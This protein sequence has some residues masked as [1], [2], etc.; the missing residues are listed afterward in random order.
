LA[1]EQALKRHKA[2]YHSEGV[3][4]FPSSRTA[5]VTDGKAAVLFKL[6]NANDLSALEQHLDGGCCSVTNREGDTLLHV[7]ARLRNP[8]LALTVLR[9]A[10]GACPSS[11]ARD[12]RTRTLVNVQ[13]QRG[14][15]ALARTLRDRHYSDDMVKVWLRHGADPNCKNGEK[16]FNVATKKIDSELCRLIRNNCINLPLS[17]IAKRED[18]IEF[19][20]KMGEKM[21]FPVDAAQLLV[22]AACYKDENFTRLCLDSG[23][24][25]DSKNKQGHFALHS[26]ASSNRAD[27]IRLLLERGADPNIR[28]TTGRSGLHFEPAMQLMVSKSFLDVKIL[29]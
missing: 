21:L 10:A 26:A 28:S 16:L 7:A 25:P 1:S 22:L 5:K 27:L 17:F 23:A 29:K 8:D 13:N 19:V 2:E 9:L 3:A 4:L 24:S 11:G 12:E 6:A 14:I 18:I 20:S 15:S